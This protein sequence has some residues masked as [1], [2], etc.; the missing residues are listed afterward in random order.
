MEG[1]SDGM[2]WLE[3]ASVDPVN[4][5]IIKAQANNKPDFHTRAGPSSLAHLPGVVVCAFQ[6]VPR[7]LSIDK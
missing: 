1:G 7:P 6:I 5:T 2:R 4:R 3:V